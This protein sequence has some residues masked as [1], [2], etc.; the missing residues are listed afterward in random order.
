LTSAPLSITA[1]SFSSWPSLIISP[2]IGTSRAIE[3][4]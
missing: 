1:V 3:E 2:R 4:N